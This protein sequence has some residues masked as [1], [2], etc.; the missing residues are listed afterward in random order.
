MWSEPTG[1]RGA[2]GGPG[3]AF[4][5]KNT[6]CIPLGNLLRRVGPQQV[7]EGGLRA[8]VERTDA[9][10]CPA[11]TGPWRVRGHRDNRAIVVNRGGT[12]APRM[13]SR[14]TGERCLEDDSTRAR[15]R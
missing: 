10:N 2:R 12:T 1:F 8:E 11:L 15:R 9:A 7:E 6:R 14:R 5:G 4:E 13:I 3:R